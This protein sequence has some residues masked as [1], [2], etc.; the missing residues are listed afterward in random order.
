MSTNRVNYLSMLKIFLVCIVVLYHTSQGYTIDSKWPIKDPNSNDFADF[1]L[2]FFLL[3]TNTYF[4]ALFFFISALFIPESIERRGIKKYIIERMKRLGIPILIFMF[5][6]FPLIGM[7][8]NNQVDTLTC[9][10][11]NYFSFSNG[12]I[13]FFHTWFLVLLLFFTI[14]YCIYALY[15]ANPKV[16]IRKLSL[17]K[18]LM[19]SFLV[20]I[21]VFISRISFTPGFV[22]PVLYIEPSRLILY[23][24]MF[25]LGTIAC[26]GNLISSIN[27]ELTRSWIF[28]SVLLVLL[29]PIIRI[30]I[31]H[32]TVIIKYNDTWIYLVKLNTL[33][34]CFWET[35]LCFGI[36]IVLIYL[37]KKYLDISNSYINILSNSSLGVYLIHPFIVILIQWTLLS[38]SMNTFLKVLLVGFSS[39]CIS[40]LM[41]H[42]TKS[43]YT[44]ITAR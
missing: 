36:S 26:K 32:K 40:F 3:I 19:F 2:N 4:M 31:K 41:V 13:N 34:V 30:F 1:M 5:M 22:I 33:I 43:I 14:L 39:I 37:F 23:I 20:S 35:F 8:R 11:K 24:I 29:S 28:I 25:I 21:I 7:L 17:Q 38:F 44:F 18:T 16:F 27:K 12:K 10:T 42:I 9:I 6:V 15:G